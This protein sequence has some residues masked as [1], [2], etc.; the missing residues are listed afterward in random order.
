MVSKNKNKNKNKNTQP[1]PNSLQHVSTETMVRAIKGRGGYFSDIIA[2]ALSKIIP[3]GTF[4]SLG[5]S[6]GG[7]AGD[8]IGSKGGLGDPGRT[9]GSKLGSSLGAKLAQVVGFGKYSVNFNTLGKEGTSLP[10]GYPVPSFGT[11]GHETRIRHREYVQ[12]IA[13]PIVPMA[14]T[15]LNFVINPGN[16]TLFPWL[17]STAQNFEQYKINGMIFEFVSLSSDITAGGPL[18]SVILATDYNVLDAPFADK[19]HMENSQYSISTKPSCSIIHA[20]E[21]DPKLTSAEVKYVRDSSSSTSSSQDARWYDHGLFQIATVG[22]PGSFGAVL[23]ELWISYDIT[24]LKPEIV[25]QSG[26]GSRVLAAGAIAKNN[27][28]GNTPTVT[29]SVLASAKNN[30]LTFALPGQYSITIEIVGTG[31]VNPTAIVSSGS[32]LLVDSTVTGSSTL[33]TVQYIINVPT[34]SMTFI[35]DGTGSTT[36][37]GD[38]TRVAGYPNALL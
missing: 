15:N 20:I 28:F 12:D 32:F 25:S 36:I 33:I 16:P 24:L 14:F 7:V 30:T 9:I 3:K 11:L 13:V 5:E 37:T 8:F 21:C 1:N 19:I 27:V 18:G 29:G 35:I 38:T 23:G 17:N 4:S 6:A 2:P 22:L 26:P 31:L 34:P 10:E